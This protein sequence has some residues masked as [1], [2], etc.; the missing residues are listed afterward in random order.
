MVDVNVNDDDDD[1][2]NLSINM[3]ND[4]AL[5]TN[6]SLL[7][8]QGFSDFITNMTVYD[9]DTEDTLHRGV[10]NTGSLHRGVVTTGYLAMA[11][12]FMSDPAKAR[13]FGHHTVMRARAE[14]VSP[15]LLCNVIADLGRINRLD[16][17]YDE[18]ECN[19]TEAQSLAAVCYTIIITT[20][21]HPNHIDMF[22][23]LQVGCRVG[24]YLLGA[25][26]V[27]RRG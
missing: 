16:Q 18:A 20:R 11:Y 24:R 7:I 1:V 4:A 10:V 2:D 9:E 12:Y 22:E 26:T 15:Q 5:L 14:N 25:A 19:F 8:A 21:N 3:D 13:V 17:R 6:A 23:S 27:E